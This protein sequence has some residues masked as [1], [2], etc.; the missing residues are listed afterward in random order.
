MLLSAS[1][2]S[3]RFGI[4]QAL[5]DVS[6]EL[7]AG[8]VHALMGENG[9]GKSTLGKAIAG[10]HKPDAGTITIDGRVLK[11][12]SIDDAFDAGIRIV[13]QE[14]AQCP[15][16][17]VAENL[18]LHDIPRKGPLGLF[19]DRRAMNE[20][21]AR[22]VHKLD[23]GIDVE[24]PLGL[25]APGRRQIC[26]IAASLDE[27]KA[28]SG[29]TARLI[30]FDEPTSSLSVAEADRLL[31][32]TRS[33]AAQGLTIVYVSHRMGEIFQ[34]CD[35]VTVLRDGK[36]VATSVVKDID[37]P[38]L[39]EQMIGRRIQTPTGRIK[40]AAL[41]A[42]P[43]TAEHIKLATERSQRENRPLIDILVDEGYMT[44]GQVARI[45]Q[46]L[47]ADKE[48]PA[49]A[50]KNTAPLLEVRDLSSPR[51]LKNVSLSIKGGEILGIGGLV[52]AGRSELLDAIFALDPRASGSVLVEGTPINL[53]SPGAPG[54][55]IARQMGY[56]PEDRRLQ[57]L[58][59]LLGIDENILMP[60]MPRLAKPLGF[61]SGRAERSLVGEKMTDF[62]VKAATTSSLPGE[63]SGGNQ[64]KLLIARWMGRHTKVLL[65][66]EPTRGI[67]VGTKTEVYKLVRQAAD[68]GAAVL[69][70]S[71]EMPE[72]LALSDRIVVMCD[73]RITGELNDADM[74]QANIL[75][76]AT[77]DEADKARR[78]KAAVATV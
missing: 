26:Q 60:Y 45:Q 62:R 21:A 46:Q 71:S 65:L 40:S 29:H 52:G 37:E 1:H 31:E 49:S 19:I 72:L 76:L 6:I 13:H 75:R 73:G 8:E 63:L 51:K 50:T 69:L 43:V 33:L 66:D 23:P 5:D 44:R 42:A 3:K 67:D 35:R 74:T 56:V 48:T 12:G 11:P 64:Q 16:L 59:F 4:T 54:G 15:N 70:V 17:S 2:I 39:V 41:S 14:L 22:L 58:F 10:L 24:A 27:G 38:T 77:S 34:V 36:Y 55:P 53:R 47:K 25:L 30:V 78:A 61:R 32:I 20:R 7:A 68:A 9:A 18:C 57:G 28:G